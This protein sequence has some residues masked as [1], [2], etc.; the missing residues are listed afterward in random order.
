MF[1]TA[2]LTAVENFTTQQGGSFFQHLQIDQTVIH[3]NL[4][5]HVHGFNQF[6][7][8]DADG[9][10]FDIDVIAHGDGD[11]ITGFQV[12]IVFQYSGADFRSLGIEQDADR[13]GRMFV[14]FNDVADHAVDPFVRGM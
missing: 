5:T 3:G 1:F 10:F 4:V 13:K 9:R 14:Q 6:V 8:V 7:I 11:F 2:E 12:Q